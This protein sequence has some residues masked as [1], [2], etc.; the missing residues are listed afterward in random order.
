[1]LVGVLLQRCGKL[2]KSAAIPL[3]ICV[4][5]IAYP[6][7]VILQIPEF[8]NK[9]PVSLEWLIP[10]SMAW[11][12]FFMTAFLFVPLGR[13][14]GW[15]RALTGAVVMTAGLANTSF[16]GFPVIEALYGSEG[17]GIAIIVDQAGSFLVLS[18]VAVLFAAHS[19]GRKSSWADSAK[20]VILFP[21]FLAVIAAL[22]LWAA[23]VHLPPS[24]ELV[25]SKLSALLAPLALISVGLQLD[26]SRECLKRYKQPLLMGLSWKLVLAPLLLAGFYVLSNGMN[27]TTQVTL[28]EAAMA[29][30]ITGAIVAAE[31]DLEPEF[32]NL[33]VGLGIPLS[34]LTVPVWF[35]FLH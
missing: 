24:F 18:T 23:G 34:L 30:M 17:L 22:V 1:M 21:P 16:V 13:R 20:Q 6:A 25:L 32:A 7:L 8:L 31:Y 26:L 3:N 12:L 33:M 29:P 19:A 4:I 35:H 2:P 28:L 9:T 11:I 14:L 10:A 15:S 5:Y 27:V